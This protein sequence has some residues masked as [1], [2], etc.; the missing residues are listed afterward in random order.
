MIDQ[1]GTDLLQQVMNHLDP[2]DIAA[3]TLVNRSWS[4]AVKEHANI[5]GTNTP[6][7]RELV[8]F[9][10]QTEGNPYNRLDAL[11]LYELRDLLYRWSD[12]AYAWILACFPQH[13]NIR[14]V[15]SA[16]RARQYF[17]LTPKDLQKIKTCFTC[18]CFFRRPFYVR[19]IDSLV[20][21][22]FA[23]HG[24]KRAWQRW[25]AKRSEAN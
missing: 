18:R 1:L 20:G 3:L 24:S 16:Y 2:V 9:L 23:K 8:S 14:P 21:L 12:E 15:M 13:P 19:R 4:K 11:G 17:G 7:S 10:A 6:S 22:A 5:L 25:K